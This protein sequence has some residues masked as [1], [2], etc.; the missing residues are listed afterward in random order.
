V[1][2]V[3]VGRWKRRSC[4]IASR[5]FR[6][7]S[8]VKHFSH[9]PFGQVP[10]LTDGDISIFETGAILLHLGERSEALMPADPRGRCEALEWTFAALNSV[11]MA[12][13][14]WSILAFSGDTGDTPGWKRFDRFLKARLEHLEPV[15][16]GREWLAGFL[17][18]RRHTHGGCAAPCRSV[19]RVGRTSRLSRLRRARHGSPVLREGTCRPGGAFCCGRLSNYLEAEIVKGGVLPVTI[20]HRK[21]AW[22]TVMK[23]AA[24]V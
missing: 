5:A 1:T 10:W 23:A 16:A 8:E 9:Q 12:S 22:R 14:P 11:E 17:L 3:C 2:Y 7:A 20:A 18:R 21:E 24:S 15:L 19:R 6:F 13:L 4:P